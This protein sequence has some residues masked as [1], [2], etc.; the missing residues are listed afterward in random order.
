MAGLK[1]YKCPCCGGAIEFN[2]SVQKMKCPY[3]DTEFEMSVL[4]SYDEELKSDGTDELNW[5][6]DSISTFGEGEADNLNMYVCK[7]CGGE[8]VGDETMAASK[9]PFCDNPIVVMGKVAGELKPDY[10]IPFKLDKQHAMAKFN[11][12]L[13][14][15]KLLP[16]VFAEQNH[17]EEIKGVYVPVWLYDS[18]ATANIRYKASKIRRYSDKNYNYTE[19]EVYSVLRAGDISFEHVPVDGS[20]KMPDE[21]MESLEP[22]DFK[23]AVNF[24]TAYFAGYVA[25]RYDVGT[26]ETQSRANERVHKSTADAFYK[27]VRGY[28]RVEYTSGTIRLKEGN[29]SYAMYPVW[30]LNTVWNGE[31]YVFAMNGQ[32]GKFVGNLPA[33]KGLIKSYFMKYLGIGF[34]VS[35][36]IMSLIWVL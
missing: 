4:E 6:T 9:C 12:H 2:T 15:K 20:G 21:L 16:K 36:A 17:I 1:E 3:C 10:I 8:I 26:V 27:T 30:I 11:E 33:D 23:E 14:G 35:M 31:K 18:N 19:T 25:D 34:A 5:N 22:F 28:D 32:T 13:K 29:T 7:S 24:Q